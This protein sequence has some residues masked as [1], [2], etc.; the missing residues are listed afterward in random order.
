MRIKGKGPI[1]GWSPCKRKLMLSKKKGGEVIT[2]D[3]FG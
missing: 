1:S 2:D 3:P